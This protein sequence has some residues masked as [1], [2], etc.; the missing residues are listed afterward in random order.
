MGPQGSL[1]MGQGFCCNAVAGTH[2]LH[3]LVTCLQLVHCVEDFESLVALCSSLLQGCD[4]SASL[5]FGVEGNYG[6]TATHRYSV[7]Q[8]AKQVNSQGR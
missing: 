7:V 5:I 6:S 4:P 1:L 8:P 2:T 3:T